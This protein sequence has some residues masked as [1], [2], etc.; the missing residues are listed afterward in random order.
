VAREEAVTK[1]SCQRAVPYVELTL[2]NSPVG[3]LNTGEIEDVDSISVNVSTLVKSGHDDIALALSELT[4]AV[5][6]NVDLSADERSYVL[7]N[8]EELSRQAALP[9]YERAKPN[10]I[11][12]IAAG[13]G[14]S[15][16][17]AGSLA[18]VWSTWAKAIN[19]YF[20][21]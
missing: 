2:N 10:V 21:Y 19:D 18:A 4:N 6:K 5:T 7:E 17:A 20:D 13:V 12:S 3:I 16:S 14:R 15:L 8:L 1:H 9:H 11:K